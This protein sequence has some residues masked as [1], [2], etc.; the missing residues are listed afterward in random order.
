MSIRSS[1]AN[2]ALAVCSPILSPADKSAKESLQQAPFP[3]TL[4][5]RRAPHHHH[6]MILPFPADSAEFE[7]Y[8]SVMEAMADE[9]DALPDPEPADFGREEEEEEEGGEDRWLDSYWES[10]YDDGGYDF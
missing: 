4:S 3:A 7:E 2:R 1:S 5:P 6:P 8:T 10:R 9:A